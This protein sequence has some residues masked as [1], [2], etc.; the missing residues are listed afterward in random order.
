MLVEVVLGLIFLWALFLV[1]KKPEG[2]PPGLWGFPLIGTTKYKSIPLQSDIKKLNKKYG[3]IFMVRIGTSINV[4]ICNYEITKEV[5]SNLE[6]AH[7]PKWSLFNFMGNGENIGLVGSYGQPWQDGRRFT[8]RH[9]RQLGLGKSSMSGAIQFEA[10]EMTKTFEGHEDGYTDL[11]VFINAVVVNIIWQ[12]VSNQRFPADHER[13]IRFHTLMREWQDHF[14][15]ITS[16]DFYPWLTKVL[17]VWA[18]HKIFGYEVMFKI[19]DQIGTH[20]QELI[21]EHKNSL[22]PA[23][24]RDFIDNFLIKIESSKNDPDTIYTEKNLKS[25]IWDLFDAG[26]DTVSTTIRWT[27]LYMAQYPK[28][29]K[30]VQKEIDEVVTCGEQPSWEDKK[31]MPYTEAT[32]NEVH[33]I[34]SLVSLGLMRCSAS[35]TT[36]R[37]Y[38]IPKGTI[39]Y[40]VCFSCHHDEKYWDKPSEFRPERFLDENNTCVIPREG[41]LPFGVGRRQCIGEPLAKMEL[42]IFVTTLLQKITFSPGPEGVNLNP[43]DIPILNYPRPQKLKLSIRK[44]FDSA[45]IHLHLNNYINNID[46]RRKRTMLVEVVLGLIFLWALFLVCKKPEGLPPGLWGFPLIGTTKYKS[47]PLQSDIKK[48]NKKYGDIFMVRIGTSINVFICN[49]EITKEVCSNLEFA[50]RPKWSLFNFMGNGENIGIMGSYGQPWQDGRRF[51]LRHLRQLGLGKSSMTG[52][53][54]FEALE[55][56]KTFEG[57]ED[58][59]TDLGVFINA[60]VVNIIWQLVSNQRFPADHERSI[61]FHTLMREWQDHFESITSLDF[62]P[63][64]TKVLPVWAKHKIFGYEV[65]FKIRDQIGTHLQELIEEHKN[66]LDPASPRD[67]IDN[68]LIKIESSKNDPDTIYTEKNLKSTIWDLFDAGSDTVSTTIRWTLLY[69]AQY[70][71]VQKKVQK[72]IDEVVPRGEQPSWEDKM[73][74]PYTEATINEVHRIISLVS[75]GLM[76]CSASD[77]TIRDYSIPKGTIIYPICFSCHHDEKYWD[78]PSEF[79]PERFLDEN[80]TCVIPREGFLPF[81][82]GRR[83][84]IGEPLA[85]MELFI[86]VT[87]LLQKITFL[88][89]PEGVNLNPMDIPFLNYPRPQKLKLSIRKSFDS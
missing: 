42:F 57:H 4:F 7:R 72:E 85:K 34:I 87:T 29:Q 38:S 51:T 56:T 89:G 37:D 81:G 18:K 36:I 71:E 22:D 82:V 15:S 54:Q 77:T 41:F 60:V 66:S 14:E 45:C 84:C 68:F 28:V 61:R 21:E 53:I 67:F 76:H 52:A 48:L 25:T 47:V 1:C 8:L 26:S 9:L 74:M 88:P 64:L 78:K 70:P 43:M 65:M 44:S 59:Y 6:F 50:H 2:L 73:R 33:R 5:C 11:G 23:S 13:S 63:W 46:L 27:L 12:L 69:M 10:L 62:Y 20:L 55:M 16:L 80:N 49:Y 83:Q 31:R 24:P 79:R 32:I 75:T 3:D 39:I 30:K 86:F 58:G 19:R 35:D 40:P 17:P